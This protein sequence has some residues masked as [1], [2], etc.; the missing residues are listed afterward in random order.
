MKQISLEKDKIKILLLEGIH[1][2]AVES[3]KSDGYRNIEL[4][5][6]SLDDEAIAEKLKNTHILGI[7]SRTQ[8][9]SRVLEKADRLMAVG[10]F[11]IGTNQVDLGYITSRGICVFNAPYSNTR[12]VAELT[13][14]ETIFLLRGI[15]EKNKHCHEGVWQKS[16]ASSH[17]ARG[18]K[19]GIVGYG[20]IGTQLSVMAESLGMEVYYY[21][22][23]AKLPLG[24]AV[25]IHSL[26]GLLESVDIVTLHV[27]E[28]PET[29]NMMNAELFNHMKAGSFFINNARGSLVDVTALKKALDSG[30]LLGAAIDVFPKEPKSN[31]EL[32]ESQLRSYKNVI[33]TPHIGGSTLEA[34]ENIGL[35][36]A[37][38]LAKYSDT[39]T[40]VSS[41]NFPEVALPKHTNH[42]RILHIHKNEPGVMQAINQVFSDNSINISAQYL[43]TNN[44]IGYVVIDVDEAVS[45]LALSAIRALEHTIKARRLF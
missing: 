38:K 21:D 45:E 33:L 20:N 22:T 34:Q 12:S 5:K 24:N 43:Q 19:L 7:R 8:L 37:E 36:V 41:V 14:A 35:E 40:T 1:D 6:E 28:T 13:L 42:H 26:K 4:I 2:K 30:K 31:E 17:E 32:F 10:C 29:K 3:L 18:K 25:Q 44:D 27:P 39:G 16:A 9:N 15:P 23:E 11:C